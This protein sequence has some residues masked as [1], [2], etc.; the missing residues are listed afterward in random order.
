ML[1]VEGKVLLDRRHPEALMPLER[2]EVK[3]RGKKLAE[4]TR[5]DSVNAD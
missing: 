4:R 5:E 1:E 3:A 2:T